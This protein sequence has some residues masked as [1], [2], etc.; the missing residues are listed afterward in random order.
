MEN[1]RLRRQLQDRNDSTTIVGTSGPAQQMRS[2]IAR[3]AATDATVLIRGESGTGKTLIAHA[4]HDRSARAKKPF[5]H[6][7]CA[8][9]PA[10]LIDAEL[11]GHERDGSGAAAGGEKGRVELA[12][13]GTLFLDDLGDLAPVMQIKL[14][15]LLEYREFER[16]GGA[17]TVKAD[18][19]VLV[20]TSR[21]LEQAI[22]GGTRPT[23]LFDRLNVRAMSIPPLR[24]RKAD[25]LL[26]A[27]RFLE[28]VSRN[29]RRIITR[30][31]PPAIDALMSHSWPGNVR[32]LRNVLERAVLA[33]DGHTIQ[34][35]HLPPTF[36][37]AEASGIF[38]TMSLSDAMNAFERDMIENA[39]KAAGGNRSK[40]ARL[41]D[42]TE[43]ILNYKS[44]KL[45]ID[46]TEFKSG[47][48]HLRPAG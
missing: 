7:S 4:I 3:V 38:T 8:T 1:A 24:D 34:P 39:L 44:K 29:H 14:R 6:M 31:S 32:E 5:V 47:N 26:L 42:T 46:P 15:R 35:H 40:A 13:G 27:D 20:A 41:L 21:D 45:G 48:G 37:T 23:D 18:V 25:L 16:V 28:Q 33:C 10:T 9:L 30:I 11:F 2:D 43:R 12:E 19:R 36:R 22:T 17:G